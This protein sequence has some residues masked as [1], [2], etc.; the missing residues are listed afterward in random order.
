MR[1]NKSLLKTLLLIIT[2]LILNCNSIDIEEQENN[3][4]NTADSFISL[5]D[6]DDSNSVSLSEFESCLKYLAQSLNVEKD[7]PHLMKIIDTDK[8][9]EI[10]WKEYRTTLAI[11][12]PGKNTQNNNDAF[13]FDQQGDKKT[14]KL[15]NRNGEEKEVTQQELFDIMAKSTSEF[16]TETSDEGN[17]IH[18]DMGTGSLEDIAKKN[19][20]MAKFIAIGKWVCIYI[21]VYLSICLSYLSYLII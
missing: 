11:T 5:C 15:K 9:G 6:K 4:D 10:S 13:N 2:I 21:F 19:P 16:P 1:S 17:L 3:F 20:G 12:P 14:V 7:L 18:A 8:N